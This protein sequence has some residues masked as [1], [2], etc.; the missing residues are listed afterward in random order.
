M[1]FLAPAT[2]EANDA[3]PA[4]T[5][6]AAAVQ[7]SAGAD[8][9]AN[10]ANAT[11]LV[12]EAAAAGARLVVLPEYFSHLTHL[13]TMVAEAE[14]I[15]GPTSE[16]MRALAAKHQIT[17]LAGTICERADQPGKAYN[18]SLLF[19]PQGNLLARYRKLHLFDVELPEVTF[20]ESSLILPGSEVVA[21]TT[22]LG[23]LGHATCYDLRFP[24]LFRELSRQGMHVLLFP[25]AFAQSTGRAHWEILL[26]ARAIENQVFVVAAN[27]YGQHTTNMI[28]YGHSMILDPWGEVLAQAGEGDTVLTADLD[29]TRQEE[30][31]R[32]LPALSHCRL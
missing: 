24:E 3:M 7:L 11:R 31:R 29:F 22:E 8:K 30:I 14:P 32:R 16:A 23:C 2:F 28:T 10:L 27:Q 21:C 9:T 5:Y 25:S 26:R 4:Q 15:P 6:R 20:A 19:D 17:L 12:A 18:T 1:S 13:R